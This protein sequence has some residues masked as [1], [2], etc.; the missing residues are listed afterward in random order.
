MKRLRLTFSHNLSWSNQVKTALKKAAGYLR[1]LESLESLLE[2]G[3]L[4]RTNNGFLLFGCKLWSPYMDDFS[5]K[6]QEM[7]S[8]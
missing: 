5:S 6:I 8:L 7:D 2:I 3:N 1:W 4:F